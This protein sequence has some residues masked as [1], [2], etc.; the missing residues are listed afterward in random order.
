[1]IIRDKDKY[2]QLEEE[3][4]AL[5]DIISSRNETI[6]NLQQ[7]LNTEENCYVMIEKQEKN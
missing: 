4:K 2:K 7:K 3:N 6:F 5:R 1:M